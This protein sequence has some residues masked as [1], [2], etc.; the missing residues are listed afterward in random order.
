MFVPANIQH[1]N[2]RWKKQKPQI[3]NVL[4]TS[5]KAKQIKYVNSLA[6]IKKI[7]QSNSTCSFI[8]ILLLII[9]M[10]C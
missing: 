1:I 3:K 5:V 9:I 10:G 6:W 7:K 4:G 2:S 8:I